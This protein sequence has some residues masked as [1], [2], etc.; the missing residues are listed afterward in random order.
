MACQGTRQPFLP[1]I[2]RAGRRS[3]GR[4]RESGD[5]SV[6]AGIYRLNDMVVLW[7]HGQSGTLHVPWHFLYF[8]PL[9]QGQ[10]SL[11]PTLFSV[12]W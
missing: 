3:S 4:A 5:G 9:P 7:P 10:G 6:A 11:R 2:H 12:L 8:L 1:K